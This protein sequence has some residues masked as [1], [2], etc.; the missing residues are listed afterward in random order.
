M[1]VHETP[2]SGGPPPGRRLGYRPPDRSGMGVASLVCGALVVPSAMVT[3]IPATFVMLVTRPDRGRSGGEWVASTVF[4]TAPVI[5]ALLSLIFGLV[6]LGR[7]PLRSTGFRTGAAGLVLASL[8][9]VFIL[10]PS[11]ARGY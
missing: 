5:L 11:I 10:L 1:N 2:A 4:F 7:A 6:A 3:V 8:E 9:A